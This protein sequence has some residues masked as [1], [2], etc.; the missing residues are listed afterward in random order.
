MLCENIS[1]IVTNKRLTKVQLVGK[2]NGS[3]LCQL[4]LLDTSVKH[5]FW[6]P[7]GLFG[8]VKKFGKFAIYG[9]GI[10]TYI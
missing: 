3:F 9:S 4:Q 7:S 10:S 5:A 8:N 2:V 6:I 1:K